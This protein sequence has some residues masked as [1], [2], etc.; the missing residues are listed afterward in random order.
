MR[1]IQPGDDYWKEV[2]HLFWPG[3]YVEELICLFSN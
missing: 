3:G 2:C 1:A